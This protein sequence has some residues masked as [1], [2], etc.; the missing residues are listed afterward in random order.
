MKKLFCKHCVINNLQVLFFF[1]N[2]CALLRIPLRVSEKYKCIQ[3]LNV[4]KYTKT[5]LKAMLL[6][7]WSLVTCY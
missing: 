5:R 6:L 3:V 1:H 7:D 2:V 4:W